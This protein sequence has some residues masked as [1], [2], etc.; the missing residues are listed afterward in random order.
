MDSSRRPYIPAGAGVW[1]GMKPRPLL[2]RIQL[3]FWVVASEDGR[4]VTASGEVWG[5]DADVLE[6]VLSIGFEAD[7]VEPAA[8]QSVEQM[9][10]NPS[11][12]DE[13]GLVPRPRGSSRG[14][15][16]RWRG[17]HTG[18]FELTVQILLHASIVFGARCVHEVPCTDFPAVRPRSRSARRAVGGASVRS[19]TGAVNSLRRGQCPP[20]LP[21]QTRHNGARWLPRE[22]RQGQHPGARCAAASGRGRHRV[23]AESRSRSP[24]CG[25]ESTG[26]ILRGRCRTR[27]WRSCGGL[28]RRSRAAT[29][30]RCL[31]HGCG[32]RVPLGDRRRC[33]GKRLSGPRGLS[34]VV[35]GD[36]FESF[37]F[38]SERVE[39]VPASAIA[40]SPSGG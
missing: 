8:I 32:G 36:S 9:V 17:E 22:A 3:D 21:C 26:E 39:R 35:R 4:G 23:G 11:C 14:P 38:A 19:R 15:R 13:L 20:G 29:W 27:T 12:S 10:K 6:E 25:A 5:T 1:V 34:Q 28:S 37:E 40:S 31:V 24:G 2:R 7:H 18:A 30:R 16:E 33:G